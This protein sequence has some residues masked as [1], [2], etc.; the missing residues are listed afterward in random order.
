MIENAFYYSNP[1]PTHAIA[2]E[3][4]PPKHEFVRKLLYKDLNKV[5][6]E[7]VRSYLTTACDTTQRSWV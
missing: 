4:R 5:S 7:K 2:R 6:T 1:P 3:M